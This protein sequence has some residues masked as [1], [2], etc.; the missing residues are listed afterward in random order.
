[1]QE[2]SHFATIKLVVLSSYVAGKINFRTTVSKKGTSIIYAHINCQV[3]FRDTYVER[4]KG[5]T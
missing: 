5:L 2:R 1:M 3:L 4:E